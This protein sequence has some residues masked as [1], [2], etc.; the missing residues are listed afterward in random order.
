MNSMVDTMSPDT[1]DPPN[2]ATEV[3]SAIVAEKFNLLGDYTQLVSER[4]QNFRL[5]TSD[6]R[7]FVVKVT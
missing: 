4:D 1:V 5:R 2:F 7:G 6:G 3:V